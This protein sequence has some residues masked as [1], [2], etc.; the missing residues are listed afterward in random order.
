MT[1]KQN[2]RKIDRMDG[3]MKRQ[4][5]DGWMTG[6]WTDRMTGKQ[7]NRQTGQMDGWIEQ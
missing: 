7:K 5:I 1:G 2:D 3:W 6:G 4:Q